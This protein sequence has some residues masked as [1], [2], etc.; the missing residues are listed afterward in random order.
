MVQIH[1]TTVTDGVAQMGEVEG[2]IEI[3]AGG[4]VELRPGGLHIMLMDLT[5]DL[6]EGKTIMVTLTFESGATVEIEVPVI[7]PR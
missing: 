1:Q 2:G 7:T 5:G 6:V 3:P 4:V